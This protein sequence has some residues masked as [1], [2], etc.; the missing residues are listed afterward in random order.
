MFHLPQMSDTSKNRKRYC[1]IGNNRNKVKEVDG[2]ITEV[3]SDTTE[4]ITETKP[5]YIKNTSTKEQK[6]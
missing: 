5:K 2:K 6:K 3:V 1:N 4:T